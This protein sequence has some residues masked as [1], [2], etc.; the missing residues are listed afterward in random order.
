[1]DY[2]T[3]KYTLEDAEPATIKG[4]TA[5]HTDL[6]HSVPAL[7]ANSYK[8]IIS[9]PDHVLSSSDIR[10]IIFD[11]VSDLPIDELKTFIDIVLEQ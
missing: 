2:E 5:L 4:E 6:S 3:L 8:K 10:N 7:L 1:M 9:H 11:K